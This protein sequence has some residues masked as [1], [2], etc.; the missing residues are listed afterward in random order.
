MQLTYFKRYRMEINLAGREFSRPVPEGYRL[1]P[2][3]ASLLDAHAEAKYGSF[4]GE[5]D[6]NVFPC[7]GELAGC[8]RLMG[9]IA[10]KPGFVPK[11]TWLAEYTAPE[12]KATNAQQP[13]YCGTIQGIRARNG[14]GSV[15]NLGITPAHRDAGLGTVLLFRALEGFRDAGINRVY[16]EVTA[17]NEGAIRLYHRYGFVTVRTVFKT[18]DGSR[19]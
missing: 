5:I 15:Q 3:D 19:D 12:C 13:D 1:L 4:C 11:A 6:A 7:L 16:L 14:M 9:E 18:A 17:Q 10:R 8:R 2:W